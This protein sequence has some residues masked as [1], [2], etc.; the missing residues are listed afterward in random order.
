MIFLSFKCISFP[1]RYCII[2]VD[3]GSVCGSF[4]VFKLERISS[5]PV[6]TVDGARLF[7]RFIRA[8][9]FSGIDGTNLTRE[10]EP[11]VRSPSAA[12]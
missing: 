4:F 2:H 8:E 7:R 9:G 3:S 5:F 10:G 12:Q 6:P 11:V 1:G